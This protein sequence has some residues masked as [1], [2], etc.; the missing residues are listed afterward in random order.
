ML[1]F[2]K[3]TYLS[4]TPIVDCREFNPPVVHLTTNNHL[5][6]YDVSPACSGVYMALFREDP[7]KEIQ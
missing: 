6:L 1:L 5:S 7:K 3:F 4:R 2:A